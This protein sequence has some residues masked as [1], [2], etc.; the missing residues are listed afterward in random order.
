MIRSAPKIISIATLILFSGQGIF[1]NEKASRNDVQLSGTVADAATSAPVS[2]ASVYSSE[3]STGTTTNSKGEFSLS[4]KKDN[5]YHI[6]ISCLGYQQLDTTVAG[7][8]DELRISL[9]PESFALDEIVVTAQKNKSDLSSSYTINRTSLDHLQVVD[10]ADVTSLLP[11][12]QTNTALHLAGDPQRIALHAATNGENGNPTFGTAIEVDG[13]RLSNNA[14]FKGSKY[15]QN[16]SAILGV[17]TRN[18]AS[19]SIG[20][21]EVITGIASVEYGDMTNGVVKISSKKGKTPLTIEAITKPNTKQLALQKGFA[22]GKAGMLNASAERTKSIYELASPYTSYT[23]NNLSLLYSNTFNKHRSQPV[24]FEVGLAGSLGGKDTEKDPDAFSETYEKAN[25]NTIRANAKV[26]WQLN[27]PWITS[28]ELS[29]SS[30][31]TDN[32]IAENTNKSS[33]SSIAAVHGQ[34]EGYFVATRYDNN[35]LAPIVIIP[36][37]YWY[38]LRYVDNKLLTNNA[39]LKASWAHKFGKVGSSLLLGADFSSDGNLGK[40][41]YYDDLRYAATGWREYRFDEVPFMNTLAL[42]AE[43]KINIPAGVSNLQISAG[44]RSEMT[45]INQSE[46]GTVNSTS[47]RLN[48]K[49][50]FWDNKNRIVEKLTLRAGWGQSVKLP[51]FEVLYPRPVYS[52][53][54]AFAPGT[55]ADGTTFYAYHIWP[56]ATTYNPDLKWQSSRQAEVGFELNVKGVYIYVSAFS[57]RIENAYTKTTSYSPFSYNFTDQAALNN[58]QIPSTDRQYSIDQT[59][60]VVTVI[61]KTGMRSSEVLP[62]TERQT[63]KSNNSY[64][65]GSPAQR[66]G[67]EWIVDVGKI[68]ALQTSVR[69]DGCYYHYRST[70][71][72]VQAHCPS[73]QNGADGTP[74]KYVGFYVGGSSVANG[75]ETKKLNANLTLTTHI[76]AARLAIS[77]RIESTLYSCRQSLSEYNGAQRG[78]AVD[79]RGDFVPTSGNPNIYNS[80]RFVGLYPLYY[81][82]Y[83][84]METQIPFAEKLAWAKDNDAALYSDLTKL[85]M[86]TNTD[87]YFNADRISPY[88]SANVSV[89]KEIGKV[90]SITFNATNFT[91]NMQTVNSSASNS[92]QTIYESSYVP[93][94]YYGLSLRIKLFG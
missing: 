34:D 30:S 16:N 91:N 48:G 80:N 69:F 21:I 87:Y 60:G 75:S 37:G 41:E 92:E 43:E 25:D 27:L 71:E 11:G 17:D 59:T 89:T 15:D 35:P 26:R 7:G 3:T 50:T 47:P 18:I 22:L 4:L 1:A 56:H 9:Q 31:Y 73:S 62:Y 32:L 29:G 36:A 78:F 66:Q 93:R 49:F 88:F 70:E 52:D 14:T 5:S 45:F 10:V 81:T 46:Y 85:V 38:E 61:D 28:L 54:L 72:N 53:K 74:Y 83:S 57:N 63:F 90:A 13:V 44:V 40:G 64:T 20:E 19:S 6:I 58:S 76:P 39:H 67:L 33:S 86:K 84:D 42:F 82:S 23:R 24:A 55:M 68:Q 94:F 79:D 8:V 77:L 51:S 65:N 2:F 12:G